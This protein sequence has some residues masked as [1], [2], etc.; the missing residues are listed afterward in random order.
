MATATVL[1]AAPGR[2]SA[3]APL[4]LA[5]RFV[6]HLVTIRVATVERELRRL[7]QDSLTLDAADFVP[8]KL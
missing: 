8:F 1:P 6:N 2:S 7:G 5:K 4:I 3:F